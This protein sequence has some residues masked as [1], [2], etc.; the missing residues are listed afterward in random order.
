MEH[1]P[2][3]KQILIQVNGELRMV[4]PEINKLRLNS[5]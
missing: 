5:Q 2:E 3:E 4:Q 1:K